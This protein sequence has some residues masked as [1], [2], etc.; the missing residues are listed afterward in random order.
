[1][2]FLKRLSALIIALAIFFTGIP[3]SAFY[4]DEEAV[5]TICSFFIILPFIL[6]ESAKLG[7]LVF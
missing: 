6:I 1:M 7:G 4:E 3:A 2:K 5:T